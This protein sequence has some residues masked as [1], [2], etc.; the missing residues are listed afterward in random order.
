[1][2]RAERLAIIRGVMSEF[3]REGSELYDDDLDWFIRQLINDLP[4][5][6]EIDDPDDPENDAA[7]VHTLGKL[8][9][10]PADQ[11]T[12]LELYGMPPMD[13]ITYA[14]LEFW[15]NGTVK[16]KDK[17]DKLVT[18]KSR[19][20]MIIKY[21]TLPIAEIKTNELSEVRCKF[22]NIKDFKQGVSKPLSNDATNACKDL[23]TVNKGL[24]GMMLQ[25]R[26]GSLFVTSENNKVHKWREQ[27]AICQF[28]RNHHGK[29][30]VVPFVRVYN[31]G[32][33]E[34]ITFADNPIPFARR[35]KDAPAWIGY[36]DP[37]DAYKKHHYGKKS[38]G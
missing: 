34:A 4:N 28:H 35:H 30:G 9:H 6:D 20:Q 24:N 33:T 10:A 17:N 13:E 8:E 27:V 23:A 29:A 36:Y 2:K 21:S 5:D 32:V 15:D 3:Y 1:V 31:R 7:P 25:G 18:R 14:R 16:I 37:N 19:F 11:P 26:I 12:Q 38:I 22:S